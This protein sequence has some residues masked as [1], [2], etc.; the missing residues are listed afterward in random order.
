MNFLKSKKKKITKNDIKVIHEIKQEIKP[1]IK[2]ETNG[3]IL[4][5]IKSKIDGEIL[6]KTK[7]KTDGKILPKIKL[8]E[9][10]EIL[11][12]NENEGVYLLSNEYLSKNSEQWNYNRCI[13]LEKVEAIISNIEKNKYTTL[14]SMLYFFKV[15]D[16]LICIDGNHR[17]EALILLYRKKQ[18]MSVL[19]Y[20]QQINEGNDDVEL[21]MKN[22]FKL[23]NQN[24]P[25][26]EIYMDILDENET[27]KKD[28]LDKKKKIIENLLELYKLKFKTFY[29]SSNKPRK[30][31][32]NDTLFIDLCNS[33]NFDNEENL[34]KQ[35]ENLNLELFKKKFSKNKLTKK[36]Q[37]KCKESNFYLFS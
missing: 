29:V 11:K 8:K 34:R 16:K 15:K 17:R 26:P 27:A 35:L 6:P 32:F 4:P 12:T 2:L 14:D 7:S 36:Q 31:N 5:K 1:K 30:P 23:I 25:I 18:L 28:Y 22:K 9:E 3:E 19:C 33:L 37:E 10:K 21:E 24:T 13:S 20:I